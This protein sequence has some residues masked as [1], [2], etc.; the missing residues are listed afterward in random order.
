MDI[1]EMF[2]NG[3]MLFGIKDIDDIL[4]NLDVVIFCLSVLCLGKL[5]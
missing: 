5:W 4:L 3:K 2:E 1:L